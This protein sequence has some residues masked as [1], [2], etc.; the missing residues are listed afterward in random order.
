MKRYTIQEVLRTH[1]SW[2]SMIQRC[3]DKGRGNRKDAKIYSGVTVAPR[4][5]GFENFIEDL[6]PRSGKAFTLDRFP[7][8]AGNYEPGNC[9]WATARQQAANTRQAKRLTYQGETLPIAEW[10]RRVGLDRAT[11]QYR[12]KQGWGVE[13]ALSAVAGSENH[14]HTSFASGRATGKKLTAE[15]VRT[16]V[17]KAKTGQ[18]TATALGKEF[19]VTT[20]GI[21]HITKQFGIAFKKGRPR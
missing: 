15:Q 20:S 11:I 19:G 13:K 14:T 17:T 1:M 6:G 3:V 2:R 5:L 7:K 12:L 21:C 16:I 10:A 4:W 18:Y 8:G 9:R